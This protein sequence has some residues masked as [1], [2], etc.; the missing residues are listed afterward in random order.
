M[1]LFTS[2]GPVAHFTNASEQEIQGGPSRTVLPS[3]LSERQLRHGIGQMIGRQVSI[4]HRRL[5]IRVSH[6][7][8][9]DLQVDL[10]EVIKTA[11]C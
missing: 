9:E 4:D 6:E 7:L 5:D 8:A 3:P 11:A 2:E 1:V 10:L